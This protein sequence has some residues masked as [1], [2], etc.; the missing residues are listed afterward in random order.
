MSAQ[1]EAGLRTAV[2]WADS[3]EQLAERIGTILGEFAARPEDLLHVGYTATQTGW[4]DLPSEAPG[5][6]FRREISIEY[7]ALLV[8]TT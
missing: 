8:L 4:C 3:K 5:E 6:A 1:T 7:S 2:V